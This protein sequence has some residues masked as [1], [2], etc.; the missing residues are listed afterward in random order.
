MIETVQHL[1]ATRAIARLRGIVNATTTYILSA[2]GE[3]RSYDEALREAQHAGFAEA[4]PTF[5]VDGRDA[6][7]KLAI[8]AH[9]AFGARIPWRSIPRRGIDTLDAA[10]Q[11][12]A[13]ELGYRIKLLGLARQT[14]GSVEQRVHPCMV[15]KGAPITAVEGVF[16]A[17]VAEGDFVDTIMVQGRGAGPGPTASAVVADLIDIARGIRVPTFAIPAADLR[18]LP[19]L[20]IE[21]HVGSYYIR[22]MVVDRPGVIADITAAL[23]DQQIS[24]EAMVQ[25]GRAPGE[26]VPVVI[27]THET[28]E[29]GMARALA[30]IG[31]LDSV[32]EPPRRI[33]IEA[34]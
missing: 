7:Q 31:G 18:R 27:T 8:L 14:D 2:M 21:R 25:R 30:Q 33:R 32:L 6:A 26:A 19:A 12:Y 3:G 11:R 13:R 1:A 4:D 10:D 34:L 29:A 22:L 5:D 9:L 24:V 23:R 28:T 15:R 17:V 16:N 20:P